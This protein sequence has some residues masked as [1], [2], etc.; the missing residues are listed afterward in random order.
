ML[1]QAYYGVISPEGAASILGR[2]KD[3]AHKAQQFPSDCRTLATAQ[4]IYARQLKELGVIDELIFETEAETHAAFPLLA[5]RI[6]SFVTKS[7]AELADLSPAEIVA[8]RYAKFRQMGKYKL[9]GADE[10]S[11]E[12]ALQAARTLKA[13]AD[14]KPAASIPPPRLLS[15]LSN[16]TIHGPYSTYKGKAPE[17]ALL[18]ELPPLAASAERPTRKNAKAVLDAEGPEAMAAWVKEQKRVLI[19][20]TTMRDAHQS[21]LATRVRTHDMLKACE[22]AS[23]VLHDAFSFEC[24]GGATFDVAYRFLHECPWERLRKIRAAVPNVCTQMLIRGANAVGYTSYPDNVVEEFVALAAKN[25]MDVFRIFDC[26]NDV[27]NME[28]AIKAVRKARKVAE[29]CVC[30]TSDVRTSDIYTADYYTN[31]ARRAT[32]AGAHMIGVKDMAGLLKPNGAFPLMEALRKGTDLPIHFHTHATS[33]ASL[34]TALQMCEAGC[35]IIDVATASLADATSQPSM[36][37]F[38]ASL[39][40]HPRDPCIDYLSLEPLDMH[41]GRVREL[42]APFECGMKSGSARVFDHEIPG[43]QYTNLMVQCRSMGLWSR[44]EEV[45]DMYRDVNA[46]LG[47]V[48][49]VTPSSK[50]I[51]DFALFLINKNLRADQVLD[52]AKSIDFPESVFELFEGRLGFP[53]HGFPED[54]QNA[55]LKGAKPLPTGVRSSAALDPADFAAEKARL[56]AEFGDGFEFG[57]E[58]VVSSF[59]YP[60]V[61]SDFVKHSMANGAEAVT[62]MPTHAFWYGLGVGDSIDLRLTPAAAAEFGAPKPADGAAGDAH[63]SISLDR[64]TGKKHE[65]M[66]TLEYTVRVRKD[67]DGRAGATNKFSLEVADAADDGKFDG[68]MA[69]AAD[70]AQLGAPMPGQVEKVYVKAGQEVA[71]GDQLL[72]VSAMKMEVHVKAPHA[73]K[74]TKLQ[75]AAGDK[76]VEGA[77]VAILKPN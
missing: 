37:A 8:N 44:W 54:V 70:A 35:D 21:L 17:G 12:L 40:G 61:F 49:K 71:E 45:L 63:V 77:L 67:A 20:D 2:Y 36:N 55:V 13:R 41:W 51:G 4:H 42:Y 38:V 24:W 43:G 23:V 32:E 33:A 14:A 58:E 16:V 27:S 60:K 59:L 7:I 50:S 1:S 9:L 18:A 73:G 69:N 46:L 22:E 75:V 57:E 11:A 5:E 34:A 64:I 25:G 62:N 65:S 29:V 66:R 39:V 31:L 10:K 26:F 68:P 28:V 47:N 3:D 48:V 19:T 72:T 30:Y 56:V 53:H 15:K 74:V 76:V 52:S 6:S